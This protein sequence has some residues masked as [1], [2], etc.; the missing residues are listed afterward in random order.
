MS[1]KRA[2]R[3]VDCGHRAYMHLERAGQLHSVYQNARRR[4]QSVSI[5]MAAGGKTSDFGRPRRE[6][7]RSARQNHDFIWASYQKSLSMP[8]LIILCSAFCSVLRPQILAFH[9]LHAHPALPQSDL[10]A[11]LLIRC[12]RC[13]ELLINLDSP[14]LPCAID[15]DELP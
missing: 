6:E 15:C 8:I 11:L 3:R 7:L 5:A 9:P 14:A 4:M 12:T 10:D 2:I 1:A 13:I